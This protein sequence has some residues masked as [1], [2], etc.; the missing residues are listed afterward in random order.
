MNIAMAAAA[1]LP[2]RM[3]S[4]MAAVVTTKT[5]FTTIRVLVTVKGMSK[6]ITVAKALHSQRFT[7]FINVEFKVSLVVSGQRPRRG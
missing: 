1:T 3:V 6:M 5:S 7:S 2:S 4:T